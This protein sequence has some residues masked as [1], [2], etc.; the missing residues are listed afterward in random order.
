MKH[1]LF[2]FGALLVLNSCAT[3]KEILYFQDAN[4][5][6]NTSIN[7]PKLILQ[8]N[9][10]LRITVKTL[11]E[12]AA[13]PYNMMTA[14]IKNQSGNTST[15]KLEGYII[16]EDHTINFPQLGVISTKD[17]STRDLE[18][19]ISQRL[20][21]GGHLKNPTVVVRLLNAKVTILGEVRSAGTYDFN[22]EN[23][24]VMQAIG[25]AGD[26]TIQ[27]KRR[28]ILFIREVD[29]VYKTAHIDLTSAAL[30]TSPYYHIQPNDVIVVNPNGPKIKSSGFITNI[31]GLLSV[32][33]IILS[34]VLILTR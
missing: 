2:I 3:K 12:E 29:G 4:K 13:V 16:A 9:D 14:N 21:E 31:G 25:M 19:E 11:I 5:Y 30:L 8:P 23:I 15:N 33:S 27:G 17:K 6:D 18:I 1:L 24:T 34:T 22:E 32:F 20:E 26:L 7:Y 28:D 10:I